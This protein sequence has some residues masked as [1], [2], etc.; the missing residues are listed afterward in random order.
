VI[1]KHGRPVPSATERELMRFNVAL[2]DEEVRYVR[3]HVVEREHSF[4]VYEW[5]ERLRGYFQNRGFWHT[6]EHIVIQNGR[7]WSGGVLALR[8]E[9]V[10][11]QSEIT[12]D[13]YD[14]AVK[15]LLYARTVH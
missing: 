1:D 10:V 9:C 12:A 6:V 11:L 4:V 7:V 15:E 14:A 3:R 8:M 13:E 5:Q 2:P